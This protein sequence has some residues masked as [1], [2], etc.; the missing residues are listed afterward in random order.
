MQITDLAS[1]LTVVSILVITG[2]VIYV[3]YYLVKALKSAIKLMDEVEEGAENLKLIR[4][5]LK[6]KA[7]TTFVAVLA[8]LLGKIFKRRGGEVSGRG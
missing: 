1:T 6:I 7:L 4:N 2:C 3:S 5:Q 8:G